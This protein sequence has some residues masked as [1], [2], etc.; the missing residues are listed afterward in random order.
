MRIDLDILRAEIA[1]PIYGKMSEEEIADAINAE[2]DA[3]VDVSTSDVRGAFLAAPTGDWGKLV[4]VADGRKAAPEN[5]VVLA[6][7]A[8]DTLV[9]TETMRSS[10]PDYWQTMQ[11]VMGGLVAASICDQKTA[12]TVLALARGKTTGWQALGLSR[13]LDYN[14]ILMARAA[15]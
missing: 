7:T 13:S 14:D 1:K 4:L 3:I 11:I 9:R 8:R 12:D 2:I 15:S 6:I 10:L 5:V